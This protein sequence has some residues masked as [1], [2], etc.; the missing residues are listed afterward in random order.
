M[1]KTR[2]EDISATVTISKSGREKARMLDESSKK[3]GYMKNAESKIDKILDTIREGGTLS[4][5]EEELV[6]NELKNMSEQKYKDYKELRLSPEDVL[7]DLKENY[8][9]SEAM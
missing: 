7:M 9:W 2:K 1:V 8:P 5:E 4:K 6:N 3:D